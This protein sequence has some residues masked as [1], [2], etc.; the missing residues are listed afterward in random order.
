M[1]SV[2]GRVN[3]E[4]LLCCLASLHQSPAASSSTLVPLSC[5]NGSE[6]IP[7][8]CSLL[9]T[10]EAQVGIVH[11]H[12]S[13]LV[14]TTGSEN[15]TLALFDLKCA[16]GMQVMEARTSIMVQHIL[17]CNR[18]RQLCV[19][20]CSTLI[21]GSRRTSGPRTPQLVNDYMM[22]PWPSSTPRLPTRFQPL[23]QLQNRWHSTQS[24]AS[25]H[26][27]SWRLSMSDKLCTALDNLQL[28]ICCQRFFS[29]Q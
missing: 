24:T 14:L 6:A 27:Y 23:R 26:T 1:T 28:L 29:L 20:T 17:G 13:K 9:F 2:G 3:K 15:V 4:L 11:V 18:H 5:G 7:V 12:V 19:S 25:L 10:I 22:R 16:H 8:W 21:T